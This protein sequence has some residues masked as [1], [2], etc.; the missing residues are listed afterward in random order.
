MLTN[1]RKAHRHFCCITIL[2]PK[3]PGI[4]T[5]ENKDEQLIII[6]A[7]KNNFFMMINIDAERIQSFSNLFSSNSSLAFD[8]NEYVIVRSIALVSTLPVR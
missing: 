1:P 8:L 5:R 6:I 4:R 7:D 3:K 2:S